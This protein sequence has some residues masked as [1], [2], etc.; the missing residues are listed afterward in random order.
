MNWITAI[1]NRI[2]CAIE[3]IAAMISMYIRRCQ[4]GSCG[5]SSGAVGR[6]SSTSCM[7]WLRAE[8]S[9]GVLICPPPTEA[10]TPVVAGQEVGSPRATR[11][12]R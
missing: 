1:R 4:S 11:M 8:K 12:A 10:A 6:S 2:D 5:L 7:I 9:Q 3:I